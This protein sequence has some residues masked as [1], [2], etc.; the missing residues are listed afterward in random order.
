MVPNSAKLINLPETTSEVKV[1]YSNVEGKE[2]WTVT[3]LPSTVTYR[4]LAGMEKA[5]KKHFDPRRSIHFSI[6]IYRRIEITL[7]KSE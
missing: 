6:Y 7:F 3:S 1:I 2:T 4:Y 5:S